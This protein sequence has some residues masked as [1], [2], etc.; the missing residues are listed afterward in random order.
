MG[1]GD[2]KI[3]PYEPQVFFF[4][5]SGARFFFF[6]FLGGVVVFFCFLLTLLIQKTPQLVIGI[7]NL[8]IDIHIPP[9]S[10]SRG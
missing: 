1:V 2:T 4:C 6:F 8:Y 10:F 9:R 3:N 7:G 5:F